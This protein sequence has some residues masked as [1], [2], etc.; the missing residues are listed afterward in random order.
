MN[1]QNFRY[2]SITERHFGIIGFNA[3][4]IIKIFEILKFQC[5]N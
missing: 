1:V 4:Q 2:I 5:P 3:I